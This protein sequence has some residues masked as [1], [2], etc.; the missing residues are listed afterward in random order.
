MCNFLHSLVITELGSAVT[1]DQG[2]STLGRGQQ[3]NVILPA[4]TFEMT[5]RYF[6]SRSLA[7]PR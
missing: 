1:L 7:K 3:H 4:E 6:V 2:R 5:E